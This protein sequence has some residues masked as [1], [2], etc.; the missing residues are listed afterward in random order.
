MNKHTSA[1]AIAAAI[2]VSTLGAA[3]KASAQNQI[4]HPYAWTI[5]IDTQEVPLQFQYSGSALTQV[6]K[7]QLQFYS[8]SNP[9]PTPTSATLTLYESLWFSNGK[10]LG[11]E[12]QNKLQIRQG[13]SIAI[14][15]VH[16]NGSAQ[17]DEQIAAAK[18]IMK[19]VVDANLNKNMVATIKVPM[20]SFS[21]I[22]QQIQ[23]YHFAPIVAS[24]S[25][26]PTQSDLN[27]FLESVPP[28]MTQGLAHVH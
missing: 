20:A 6:V 25:E 19:A 21:T 4:N 3:S 22:S 23:N 8:N 1:I 15:V 26:D 9:P 24:S 12:R 14:L 28:G 13:D 16:K 11:L 5:E 17:P 18:A 10:S 2:M 27:L 7:T